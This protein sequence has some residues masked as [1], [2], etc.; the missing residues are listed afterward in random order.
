M[1]PEAKDRLMIAEILLVE[2]NEGDVELMR[3][4]MAECRIA[5]P[6]HVV[7]DGAEALDYLRRRSAYA[8]ARRPDLVFLDLNLPKVGGRAVLAEI[9]ADAELR[10]IPVVVLTTSA[11]DEDVLR[12]YDLGAN[13]YVRKPLDWDEF[14][15][16]VNNLVGLWFGLVILP[17]VGGAPLNGDR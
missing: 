9:K 2:D 11:A 15:K 3:E 4:A 1:T 13:C 7:G 6:L 5:N 14:K 10:S 17:T 16:V 12:S 8:D